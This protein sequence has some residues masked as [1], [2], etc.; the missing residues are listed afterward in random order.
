MLYLV[1]S[2]TFGLLV[3]GS[4][5]SCWEDSGN[6]GIL[7]GYTINSVWDNLFKFYC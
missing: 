4:N 2:L 7:V 3:S 6:M 5:M 1:F